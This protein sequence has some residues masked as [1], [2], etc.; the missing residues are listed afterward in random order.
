M[1]SGKT[2]APLIDLQ[3]AVKRIGAGDFDTPLT[4]H[5]KDEFG[6]V[7]EAVNAMANGLKERD[8][9]KSTFARY[10]SHQVMDSILKS[11]R[12][13][14]RHGDRKRITVLFCD[15]RGFSTMSEK[16]PPEKVVKFSTTISRAWS[17]SCSATMGRSISSSVTA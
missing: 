9:V 5:S 1:I 10:V 2:S 16:L 17:R 12:E 6:Q 7:A 13:I 8:R 3:S 14:Q 15:I 4:V 11:D